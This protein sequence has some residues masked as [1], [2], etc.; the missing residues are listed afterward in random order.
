[1]DESAA[2]LDRLA[3]VAA[4]VTVALWASAFVGIRA[5]VDDFGPGSLAVGRLAVG[6]IALGV[7]VAL[8][9]FRRPARRDLALIVASGILC[10]IAALVVLKIPR[11]PRRVAPMPATAPATP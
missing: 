3:V 9:G 10:G 11:A 4:L 2:R 7:L 5:V 1:M 8:R 6:S